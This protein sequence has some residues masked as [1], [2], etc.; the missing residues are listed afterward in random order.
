M[1]ALRGIE[2]VFRV[3]G[4]EVHALRG[5]DLDIGAGDY[6]S[7]MGPS[8]S[9]KS[10]LLNLL[11]GLDQPDSGEVLV[12]GTRKKSEAVWCATDRARAWDNLMLY[13][14]E[15]AAPEGECKTPI[16]ERF[17]DYCVKCSSKGYQWRLCPVCGACGCQSS[18]Q[19]L[20]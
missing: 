10:T 18:G 8:G 19:V 5:V 15:P 20:I 6:L 12:A 13:A 2:R 9:G 3:G 1:I 17:T 14:K 16:D 11:A 7:I 4:E